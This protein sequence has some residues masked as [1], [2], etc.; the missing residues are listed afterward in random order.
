VHSERIEHFRTAPETDGLAL[1][2]DSKRCKKN[3]YDA[4]LAKREAVVRMSSDLQKKMSI[5]TLEQK[6]ARRRSANRQT[7]QNEWPRTKSEILLPLFPPQMDQLD[8]IELPEYLFRDLEL[9]S[10]TGGPIGQGSTSRDS[11][12]TSPISKK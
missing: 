2:P 9:G 4:V 3:G 8:S 12:E 1:L 5:A 10:L 6:L 11:R 7:T